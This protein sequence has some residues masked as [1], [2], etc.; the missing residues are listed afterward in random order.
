M[1]RNAETGICE[2]PANYYYGNNDN[3]IRCFRCGYGGRDGGW[4]LIASGKNV[5]LAG[6]TVR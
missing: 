3:V 4:P 2:C 5:S 1:T 6:S